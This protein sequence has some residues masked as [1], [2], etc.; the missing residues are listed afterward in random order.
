MKIDSCLIIK[1]EEKNIEKLIYQ[2]LEFSNE[3]HITDTGSTDNTLKIINDIQK[4][5]KNIF[6]SNFEWIFDFSAA[7]NYSLYYYQDSDT[8]DYKFWCDGDDLLNDKLITTLKEFSNNLFYNDDIYYIR[9][10]YSKFDKNPH[11]RTTLFKTSTKIKWFDPIHEYINILP[12][13]KLNYSL[14]DNGSLII[15]QRNFEENTEEYNNRN[16]SIFFNMEQNNVE[17][18][19]RNRYYYGIELINHGLIDSAINQFH[20]CLDE[21]DDPFHHM[22]CIPELFNYNDPNALEYLFRLL[23][24][25]ICR[26]D[27]FMYL[28]NYMFDINNYELAKTFYINCIN[29]PEPQDTWAFKYD[30]NC[31]IESLL[32]LGLIEYNLKN[33]KEAIKYNEQILDIESDN[34]IAINNLDILS[35]LI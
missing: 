9:Y 27:F 21:Y 5:H 26:K 35:T 33:Y 17:F 24:N 32:Q 23:R 14:F 11:V 8:S 7:R 29:Y 3:I 6:V 4:K 28:G 18:T 1:N 2:L 20:K 25:G 15:H 30:K 13:Y 19:S 16:L 10:K 12:E 22:L 31:V 34:D